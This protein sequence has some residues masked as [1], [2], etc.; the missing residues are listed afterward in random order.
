MPT[1]TQQLAQ[2]AYDRVNA[3]P[4]K[5]RYVS[6]AKE[7]P[8]LIHTC[9]LAQAVAFALAK[10]E[11]NEACANDLAAVLT[12]IG[13]ARCGDARQLAEHI[14]N[15]ATGVADYVRLSRDALAAAVW[16]KRHV[17]GRAGRQR[18][19]QQQAPSGELS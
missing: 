13:Y 19:A 18:Q 6:F 2:A 3:A 16:L 7:L 4:S 9:G 14:R 11:Y 8:T 5:D 10:G 17:E 12:R 1:R 15:P